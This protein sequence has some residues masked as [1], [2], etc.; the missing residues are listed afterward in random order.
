MLLLL[1]A[2]A[3]DVVVVGLV[4]ALEVAFLSIVVFVVLLLLLR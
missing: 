2:V 4:V 1:P 3:V